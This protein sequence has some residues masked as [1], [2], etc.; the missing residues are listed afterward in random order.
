MI[1]FMFIILI[2]TFSSLSAV[3]WRVIVNAI[4]Y[5]DKRSHLTILGGPENGLLC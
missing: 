4:L 2:N 1:M 3:I 5:M